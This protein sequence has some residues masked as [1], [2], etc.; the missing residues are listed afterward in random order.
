M[1]SISMGILESSIHTHGRLQ[2]S[3]IPFDELER[4]VEEFLSKYQDVVMNQISP[5]DVINPTLENC[6][7]FFKE[8]ISNIITAEGWVLLMIELSESPTRSYLINL[9]DENSVD[10]VQSIE[11]LTDHMLD[12]IINN[13]N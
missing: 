5:F 11:S 9:L 4:R 3:F 6:C 8:Q 2:D 13:E 10:T 12:S 1:Q 7:E